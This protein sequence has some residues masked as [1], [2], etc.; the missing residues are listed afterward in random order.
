MFAH[1][2]PVTILSAGTEEDPYSAE[3]AESWE[4]ALGA[5]ERPEF[6][7]VAPGGSVEPLAVDRNAVDSDFD[8][9]FDHD[10]QVTPT[11]RIVVRGLTCRVDGRPVEWRNPF[12]GWVAGWVVRVSVREG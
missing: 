8:L 4:T 5:T 3:V 11:N 1:P 12:T 10:P 7:G 9:I 2:E 6:C